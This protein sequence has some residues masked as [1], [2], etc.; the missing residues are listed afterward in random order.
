MHMSIRV[1]YGNWTTLPGKG[2]IYN[3]VYNTTEYTYIYSQ[4]TTNS[5]LVY[6][7]RF[8]A[9]LQ[10]ICP[11]FDLCMIEIQVFILC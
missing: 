9:E 3:I 10:F 4:Q 8:Q 7:C 1:S 2:K 11:S 5:M 6:F